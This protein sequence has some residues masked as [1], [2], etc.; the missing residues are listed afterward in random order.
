MNYAV[1]TNIAGWFDER[2]VDTGRLPLFAFF[3]GM[4]AG[5]LIIRL[6]VRLIRAGVRW[7]PHNVT[8]GSLHIHHMVFGVI[9]MVGAGVAGIAMP[10]AVSGWRIAAAGAFGVGTALVLDE[11]ALI[12]RL[13]DVYWTE[14]GRT[15]ID[16]LFAVTAITGLM[17][18]GLHPIFGLDGRAPDG[19]GPQ[20]AWRLLPLAAM[21]GLAA[22]TALKGKIWT[23]VLGLFI[24]VFLL[25][26]A[27]RLSRPHAPWARWLYREDRR[28]GV[29]RQK[30]AQRRERRLREPINRLKN[31]LEDALAGRPSR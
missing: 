28:R 4:V 16:A 2:I 8:A 3:V 27:I 15:S 14:Q 24:P 6:S 20:G 23:A 10:D 21:L 13:E 30:K 12:L 9:I 25:V 29:R 26:G 22:V 11:F 31:Q 5:F 7:W 19:D 17:L 1:T 18:I